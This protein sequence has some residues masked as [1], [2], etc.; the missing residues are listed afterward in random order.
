MSEY[1]VSSDG[2]CLPTGACAGESLSYAEFELIRSW[3][4]TI[5]CGELCSAHHFGILFSENASSSAFAIR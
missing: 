3:K 1:L 5:F 4:Q 2:V